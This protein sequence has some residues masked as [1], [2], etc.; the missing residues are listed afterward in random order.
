MGKVYDKIK[1]LIKSSESSNITVL[2]KEYSEFYDY[3]IKIFKLFDKAME[4]NGIKNNNS[5]I[6]ERNPIL[7]NIIK[8]HSL[9]KEE[10]DREQILSLL[11]K[12]NRK[13]FVLGCAIEDST[14]ELIN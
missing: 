10:L 1:D 13:Y 9:L 12:I 14:C 11:D 3:S 8:I 2:R 6:P 7:R 5:I 4:K